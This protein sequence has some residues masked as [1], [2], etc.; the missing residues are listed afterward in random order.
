MWSSLLVLIFSTKCDYFFFICYS[1]EKIQTNRCYNKSLTDFSSSISTSIQTSSGKG[2]RIWQEKWKVSWDFK[3]LICIQNEQYIAT[4]CHIAC[5]K[6]GTLVIQKVSKFETNIAI[7]CVRESL[8]LSYLQLWP[9]A[10]CFGSFAWFMI[11]F[12]T[13]NSRIQQFRDLI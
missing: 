12:V 8:I 9:L 11:C 1:Y 2:S 13:S 5:F 10:S 3:L 4:S 7:N 6:I